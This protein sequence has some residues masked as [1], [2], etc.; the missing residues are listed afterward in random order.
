MGL[1]TTHGCWSGAYSGFA[2]FRE[3]V[4]RAAKLPTTR[5]ELGQCLDIDW[6]SVSDRQIMGH[7]GRNGPTVK[8]SGIYDPPITD[9]VLYLLVHSDCEGKLRRGYLSALKDRLEELEPE[10]ERIT[11]HDP[12]LKGRLRQFIAGLGRAI[13]AGEHVEFR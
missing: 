8:A 3:H 13:K 7:W 2:E 11:A 5:G 1:T 6:D 4:A 12:Y 9:S 10:Y